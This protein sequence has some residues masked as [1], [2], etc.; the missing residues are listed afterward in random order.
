MEKDNKM[1]EIEYKKT[2]QWALEKEEEERIWQECWGTKL[3]ELVEEL[4]V[5]I[6]EATKESRAKLCSILQDEQF[7]DPYRGN[8]VITGMYMVAQLYQKEEIQ[9]VQIT[10]LDQGNSVEEILSYIDQLRFILY[11]IDFEIDDQ[12]EDELVSFLTEHH[13]STQTLDFLMFSHVMRKKTMI[14]KLEHLFKRYHLY[15]YELTMLN[16]AILNN[17]GGDR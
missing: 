8:N 10:I 2:E 13:T 4:N 3:L 6:Q 11:R 16:H 17:L 7:L 1:N 12:S 5:Y 9:G 15:S 14:L